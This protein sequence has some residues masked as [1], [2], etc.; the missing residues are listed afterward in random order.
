MMSDVVHRPRLHVH[1]SCYSSHPWNP[2]PME[3]F[4]GL[5]GCLCW[6]FWAYQALQAAGNYNPTS[7]AQPPQ[8]LQSSRTRRLK[9]RSPPR[10]KN[11]PGDPPKYPIPA[12]LPP[13]P[14]KASY[15]LH[16]PRRTP[17]RGLFAS[18]Q[19]EP[20]APNLQSPICN[21]SSL[22]L[23]LFLSVL[24]PSSYFSL[25]AI[26]SL[27]AHLRPSLKENLHQETF[28]IV[29]RGPPVSALAVRTSSRPLSLSHLRTVASSP[30]TLSGD[31]CSVRCLER[32]S[33]TIITLIP[34]KHS[35]WQ[36]QPASLLCRARGSSSHSLIHTP[37]TTTAHDTL[38]MHQRI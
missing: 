5:P 13:R 9:S 34:S 21:L 35:L 33:L 7:P 15:P 17:P 3:D 38:L 31:S 16:R 30:L 32:D 37:P 18:S 24:F 11:P 4:W 10:P 14:S 36:E 23:L 19:L 26:L 1:S 20:G 29:S 27:S 25:V 22:L 2:S 28:D 6:P 12:A 8:H